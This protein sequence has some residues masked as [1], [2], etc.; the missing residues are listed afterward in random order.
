MIKSKL[1]I[2]IL[3]ITSYVLL[4]TAFIGC[5]TV[6]QKELLTAYNLNGTTY[7]SLTDLCSLKNIELEQDKFNN[8]IILTKDSHRIVLKVGDSLVL[9]D[10][11]AT[12]LSHPVK[13]H[14]GAVVVPARFKEQVIDTLFKQTCQLLR[15]GYSLSKIRKIVIDAGH[16]GNDPGAIGKNGLREKDVN[17]DIARRLA[18]IL[19]CQGVD[20]VLVRSSDIFVPL[21]RRVEIANNSGADLFLSVH[22]NASKSRSLS[23]FEVYYVA[24]SVSDII[25]AKSS[26]RTSKL[27]LKNAYFASSSLD[28]RTIVWDMVYTYSRAESINLSRALCQSA[29]GNLDTRII[30]VKNAR[31]A[32]LKGVRMPAVLME[33]GFVSNPNEERLLKTSSYRTKI[34]ESIAEGLA[35][36]A[37]DSE[38]MEARNK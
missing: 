20:V 38:L 8:S 32:V 15:P 37:R 19:K 31:F 28:L 36:Y 23:G 21:P 6:P 5:A 34:A 4:V 24:P 12:M 3:R 25:R 10:D 27:N 11:R 16:G 17:L 30:G 9:V 14:N 7:Y 13:I 1:T 26:A 2:S 35:N 22:S 33:V 29:G 18:D